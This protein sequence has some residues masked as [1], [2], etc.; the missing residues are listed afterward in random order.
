MTPVDQ[1]SF[2]DEIHIDASPQRVYEVVSDVTRTGEWS[3]FTVRCEWDPGEGPAVGAHFTGHNSRPGR[4][5]DTRSEVVA[6]EPGREFAWEVNGGLVRWGYEMAPAG[7]GTAL[8]HRWEFRPEGREVVREKFGPDGVT[9][10]TEDA[11]ASIPRTLATL[12]TIIEA[13]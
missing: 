2:A 11:R 12:K 6:A 9:L 3:V 1:F 13:R 5:W 10:R 8:T 4:D 7:E